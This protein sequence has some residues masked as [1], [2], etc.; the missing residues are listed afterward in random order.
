MN[1]TE[2]IIIAVEVTQ[3]Y[4]RRYRHERRLE[5]LQLDSLKFPAGALEATVKLLRKTA[6]RQ[7]ADEQKGAQP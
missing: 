4:G 5:A 7:I 1:N 2:H 6:R 3:E